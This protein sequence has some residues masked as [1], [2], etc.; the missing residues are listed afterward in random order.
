[1]LDLISFFAVCKT[2]FKWS[3][4]EFEADLKQIAEQQVKWKA[5]Q[6]ITQIFLSSPWTQ[7]W[8]IGKNGAF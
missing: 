2:G 8:P 6:E 4:F 7:H 1:M 5:I 3:S